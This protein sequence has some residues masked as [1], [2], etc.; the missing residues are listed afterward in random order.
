MR[1]VRRQL[2][3]TPVLVLNASY[4]PISIAGARRALKMVVKGKAF[5]QE[6]NGRIAH[7]EIM[8]PSVIRLSVMTSIPRRVQQLSRKN[9]L[10]RDHN[11]CQYCDTKFHPSELTLD[12]IVPRS[13][14]GRDTWDNLVAAC[15]ACNKKKA[16]MSVEEAGMTLRRRPRPATIHTARVLLRNMGADDEQWKKYLFYDQPESNLVMRAIQ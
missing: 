1:N 4:E 12:H 3:Q 5:V 2:N 13:K 6:D 15:S 7:G 16:D 8:F 11:M 14:G 9:I 10:A